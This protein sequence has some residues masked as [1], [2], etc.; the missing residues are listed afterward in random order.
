MTN[1]TSYGVFITL[2]L[3]TALCLGIATAAR[4]EMKV[5]GPHPGTQTTTISQ[6]VPK[7]IP[8]PMQGEPDVGQTGPLPPKGGAYPTG[9]S[10]ISGLC[11]RFQVLMWMWL[12]HRIP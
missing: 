8:G 5:A 4:A 9:M 7:P 12:G 6:S 11:A 3:A 2:V 10:P 1:R